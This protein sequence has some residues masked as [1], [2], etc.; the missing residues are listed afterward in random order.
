MQ[1]TLDPEL[2]E[3]VA[4]RLE[5]LEHVR[6]LLISSVDLQCAPEDID[7]D[8]ALFGTGLGLDSLDAAEVMIGL[9]IELGVKL[10]GKEKQIVALR[11]V[12]ALVDLVLR[13]K[14]LLP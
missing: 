12:N 6:S 3:Y 4:R 14:G 11:S 9:E 8:A 2:S 7:P 13:E 1:V 5:T 10:D